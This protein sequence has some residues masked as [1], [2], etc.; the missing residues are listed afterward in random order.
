MMNTNNQTQLKSF[1]TTEL[2]KL[3]QELD[4][5]PKRIHEIEMMLRNLNQYEE[6]E[7]EVTCENQID[8]AQQV[9]AVERTF[10]L[11]KD[12]MVEIKCIV[13][14]ERK[15]KCIARVWSSGLQCNKKRKGDFC[16]HHSTQYNEDNLRKKKNCKRWCCRPG[17]YNWEHSG[18]CD[19]HPRYAGVQDETNPKWKYQRTMGWFGEQ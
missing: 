9:L 6:T 19:E 1:L 2:E 7:V 10:L 17:R 11:N 13:I 3:H 4:G 14:E 12:E 15:E 18:R 16:D 5:L 8:Y